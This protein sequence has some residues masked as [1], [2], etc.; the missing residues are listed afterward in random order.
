MM[1]RSYLANPDAFCVNVTK[2]PLSSTSMAS[3]IGAPFKLVGR[4]PH[5]CLSSRVAPEHISGGCLCKKVAV[6]CLRVLQHVQGAAGWWL[7][8]CRDVGPVVVGRV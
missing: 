4:Q 1:L 3:H 2:Y 8:E 5:S 6:A 7:L